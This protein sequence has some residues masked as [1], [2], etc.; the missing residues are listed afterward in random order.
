MSARG[1]ITVRA[2]TVGRREWLLGAL[3]GVAGAA[4]LG[5]AA[6]A[7]DSPRVDGE[8]L[9]SVWDAYFARAKYV[10]LTHVL[11]PDSPLWYGFRNPQHPPS[12][13]PA[14][15]TDDHGKS[16][17]DENWDQDGHG[18][19]RVEIPGTDWGTHMDA[20]AEFHPC[21]AAME[22]IP[23]TYTLR[24]LVVISIA[25]QAKHDIA[26]QMSLDD[27]H[28]WERKHG[29]VPAGSVVAARSDWYKNWDENPQRFL[30]E[31]G[32]FP[33]IR[34]EAIRYLHEERKIL[35]HAH[36]GMDTDTTPTLVSEDW[37]LS[38]GYP[39]VE[40]IAN[41]DLVPETGALVAFGVPRLRGTTAFLITLAAVCPP[42][43]K[44]GLVPGFHGESPLPFHDKKL[45]YSK[46]TGM[47][48]REQVCT[49]P[50][51]K[52]GLNK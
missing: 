1:V 10:Y 4:A 34:I 25:E 13:K 3:G 14:L 39:Q 31:D 11:T 15:I 48:E 49:R 32:R 16:W 36:E 46:K 24:K 22:E 52:M 5:V 37:I 9:W 17:H 29:P 7:E 51:G 43:W 2:G 19:Y 44:H 33:G 40:C 6:A 20:P 47:F 18:S 50:N 21:Q 30:A 35:F 45:A 41:L 23:P 28:A 27:V 8:N 26:Y 38:N 42:S 12:F